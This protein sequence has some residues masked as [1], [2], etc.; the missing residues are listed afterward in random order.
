MDRTLNWT[1]VLGHKTRWERN[2]CYQTRFGHS[3]CES[4][5]TVFN[6]SAV[7]PKAIMAINGQNC[8]QAV[9]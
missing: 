9:T 1:Y 7:K 6:I 3:Q 5:V 8:F 4:K 2:T